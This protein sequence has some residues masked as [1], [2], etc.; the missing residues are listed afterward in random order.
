M[1]MRVHPRPR[2]PP[3]RKTPDSCGFFLLRRG[4][5]MAAGGGRARRPA[6]EPPM[7]ADSPTLEKI[8]PPLSLVRDREAARERHPAGLAVL[9]ATEMWERFSYYSMLAMFT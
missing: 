4:P 9:F 1:I 6:E 7:Q 5:T 3:R 2:A 8:S